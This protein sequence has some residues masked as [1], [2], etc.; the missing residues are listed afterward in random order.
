MSTEPHTLAGAY[1]LD[2]LSPDEAAEF[3]THLEGCSACRA[4]VAELRAAAARMGA[5][6]MIAAPLALK[7]RVLAQV[8]RTPQLPPR[9]TPI[10]HPGRRWPLSGR[11]PR[12]LIAAAAL[13][14]IVGGVV[15]I[16]QLQNRGPDLP[17]AVAQVFEAGDA[18]TTTVPTANGGRIVVAIS[19]E[20]GKMAVETDQLPRLEGSQ[21][22]Q[23]WTIDDSPHSAGL[24]QD[25][26][27]GAAMSLPPPGTQVAITVEPAGGSE[28][29]T[30]QPIAVVRPVSG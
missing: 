13:L 4:E 28:L 12:L 29:P 1:A 26:D 23:L 3:R 24:L 22:Y 6:E 20:L 11:L 2:A 27:A 18:R 5:A 19:E 15:G 8:D 9:V 14:A 16:S 21:V 25:V 10:G 17:P 7:V 30:T